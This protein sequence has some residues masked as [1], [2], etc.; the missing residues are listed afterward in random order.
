MKKG[1]YIRNVSYF[2][3]HFTFLVLKYSSK[4]EERE[5]EREREEKLESFVSSQKFHVSEKKF[6]YVIVEK[7]FLREQ[8][9][10]RK[11]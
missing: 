5:R 9:V 3:Q 7:I 1:S 6:E 2:I 8:K 11:S 10:M 4:R